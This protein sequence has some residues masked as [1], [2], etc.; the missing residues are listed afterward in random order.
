MAAL[1]STSASPA[2]ASLARPRASG[3]WGMLIFAAAE[4]TL[5]GSIV[6]SYFYLRVTTHVWPPAGTPK[7]AVLAP[8]I[9]TGVL[10]ATLAPLHRAL[11]YARRGER[12]RAIALLAVAT[13]IQAGYL[14]VQVHLFEDDLSRF[15]PQQSAYASI[16]YVLLGAGHAHVALGLLFDIWLLV[17]LA[18]RVTPYRII[19]FEA[20][21]LY[22][23]VV[24]AISVIVVVTEL[25]PWV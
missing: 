20:I 18:S 17:R 16:Y 25:S 23:F 24:V 9:L 12:H 5:V 10:A 21:S 14:A 3:W 15:V 2:A 11:G 7:P 22:W 6:G 19:A 4:A 13:L 8:L 1:S